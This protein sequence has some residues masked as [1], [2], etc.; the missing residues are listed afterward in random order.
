MEQQ[1]IASKIMSFLQSIPGQPKPDI[2]VRQKALGE[3]ITEQANRWAAHYVLI[4]ILGLP[5][6][7]FYHINKYKLFV[8]SDYTLYSGEHFRKKNRA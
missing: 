5:A 2:P 3:R 8:F 4:Q 1:W 6:W 7:F